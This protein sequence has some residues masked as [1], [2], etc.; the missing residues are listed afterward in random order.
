MSYLTG[1]P[2]AMPHLKLE[3][4]KHVQ[5]EWTRKKNLTY[6]DRL[7]NQTP[8]RSF[9]A[10][11]EWH[12]WIRKVY[13]IL[14]SALIIWPRGW[15]FR[16]V[17]RAKA[18]RGLQIVI[19]GQGSFT[20]RKVLVRLAWILP[21]NSPGLSRREAKCQYLPQSLP[22]KAVQG[23]KD[24]SVN[25]F[26]VLIV[27][28]VCEAPLSWSRSGESSMRNNRQSVSAQEHSLSPFVISSYHR[29]IMTSELHQFCEMCELVLVAV[30]WSHGAP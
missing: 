9:C 6:S 2:H 23:D 15:H 24:T 29:V 1:P 4:R 22:F 17:P 27:A 26:A 20:L 5:P 7:Y 28:N 12:F 11:C 8:K 3:S 21:T 30:A 19:S 13:G 10:P 25:W 14:S 18:N 16:T